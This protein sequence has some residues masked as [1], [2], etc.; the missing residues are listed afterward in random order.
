MTNAVFILLIFLCRD[1]VTPRY[2]N[3]LS[4]DFEPYY[5]TSGI[6]QLL[7]FIRTVTQFSTHLDIG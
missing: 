4:R 7:R 2:V 3:N 5:F 1:R 6:L